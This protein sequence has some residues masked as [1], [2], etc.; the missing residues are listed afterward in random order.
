MGIRSECLISLNGSSNC[1]RFNQSCIQIG[2]LQTKQLLFT[3]ATDN[4][5]STMSKGGIYIVLREFQD[6]IRRKNPG[7]VGHSGRNSN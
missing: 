6:K 5:T 1:S 3:V 4:K 2:Y 7:L